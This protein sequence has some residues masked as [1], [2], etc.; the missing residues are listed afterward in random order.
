[1]GTGI[2]ERVRVLSCFVTRPLQ[3]QPLQLQPQSDLINMATQD[4]KKENL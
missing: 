3:L 4:P 1:M 2:V